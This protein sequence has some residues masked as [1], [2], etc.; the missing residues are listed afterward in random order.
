[1]NPM[2]NSEVQLILKQLNIKPNKKLGQN[3]IIDK[4]VVKKIITISEVSQN[5]VVLEIGAGL[6]NITEELVKNVK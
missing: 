6:G 2:N 4:N 5:D 1:M 3:F